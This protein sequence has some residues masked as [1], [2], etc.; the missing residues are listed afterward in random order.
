MPPSLHDQTHHAN[1]N[2]KRTRHKSAQ[3]L[4]FTKGTHPQ[5]SL[6]EQKNQDQ[7]DHVVFT[8]R[9]SVQQNRIIQFTIGN[10]WELC[11][12]YDTGLIC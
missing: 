10:S 8:P 4:S 1:S 11:E 2:L 3:A 7:G 12:D 9:N 6:T 5:P